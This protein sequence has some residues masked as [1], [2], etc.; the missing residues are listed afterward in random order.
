M[1][2]ILNALMLALFVGLLFSCQNPTNPSS[3]ENSETVDSEN[4][5][6]N[7]NENLDF[8]EGWY[9]YTTNAN[10]E[11]VQQ[12][13]FYI[14]A[15]GSIARAGSVSDEYSGTQLELLQQQF[16]YSVCVKY[17]DGITIT[18]ESAQA[19]S[20][21]ETTKTEEANEYLNKVTIFLESFKLGVATDNFYK[22]STITF[23][24][25]DNTLKTDENGMSYITCTMS[26]SNE[27]DVA[28]T[29][30]SNTNLFSDSTSGTIYNVRIYF[31]AVY[32][33]KNFQESYSFLI[34]VENK[35]YIYN[36]NYDGSTYLNYYQSYIEMLVEDFSDTSKISI[37][38]WIS[39][40]GS[41]IDYYKK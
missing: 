17:A 6:N 25:I 31:N 39:T 11:K 30:F 20:W 26:Y 24:N 32:N 12:T 1:K 22:N 9:L 28:K 5:E 35:A 2:K 41:L 16:S 27:T 23:S 13:Y 4:T 38:Y 15:D 40:R 34:N 7:D 29:A 14:N 18:F 21:A 37:T 36:S 19:P 10:S 3:T 33:G 8:S